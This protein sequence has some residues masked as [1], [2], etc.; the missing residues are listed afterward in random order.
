ML[1]FFDQIFSKQVVPLTPFS[2]EVIDAGWA[3]WMTERWRSACVQ[4]LAK[5]FKEFGDIGLTQM[6][7]YTHK[8]IQVCDEI[9]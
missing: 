2:F 8:W 7:L 3:L 5:C 9:C 6:S 1:S 4:D